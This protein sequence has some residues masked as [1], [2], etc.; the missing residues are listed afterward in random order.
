MSFTPFFSQR[1]PAYNNSS[2]F[3][4]FSQ[5]IGGTF[6]QGLLTPPL[7]NSLFDGILS[8]Q[9]MI[10]QQNNFIAS[11]FNF[12]PGLSDPLLAFSLD[13]AVQRRNAEILASIS[14]SKPAKRQ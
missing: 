10:H 13:Q 9:P 7:K 3:I 14:Q 8:F 5:L 2:N 12:A 1:H 4:P 6:G 11:N